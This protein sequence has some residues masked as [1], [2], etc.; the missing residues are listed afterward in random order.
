VD[1]LFFSY[2][3]LELENKYYLHQD[4]FSGNGSKINVLKEF[5]SQ[6]LLILNSIYR[7]ESVLQENNKESFCK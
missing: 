4:A 2:C 3:C 5:G 6:I 7:L 1:M